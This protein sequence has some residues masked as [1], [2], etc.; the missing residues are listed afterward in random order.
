VKRFA[1]Q[2]RALLK[3]HP[4]LEFGRNELVVVVAGEQIVG[5]RDSL[6]CI[7]YFVLRKYVWIGA[8]DFV[9]G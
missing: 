5:H 4:R 2:R 7:A 3:A 8:L 6:K 1:T 9:V